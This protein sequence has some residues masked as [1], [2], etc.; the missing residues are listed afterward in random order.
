MIMMQIEASLRTRMA[1]AEE[2]KVYEFAGNELR[3]A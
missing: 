3:E 2:R 1:W